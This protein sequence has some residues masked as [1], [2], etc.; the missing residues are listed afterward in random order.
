MVE[1]ESKCPQCSEGS[2]QSLIETTEMTA[3]AIKTSLR[4]R[5]ASCGYEKD[6]KAEPEK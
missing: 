1:A 5:C 4:V 6:D 3:H 2:M